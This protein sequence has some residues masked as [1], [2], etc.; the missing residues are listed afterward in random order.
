MKTKK[1]LSLLYCLD[2]LLMEHRLVKQ[3][4]IDTL[5]IS[6]PAF[7]RYKRELRSYLKQFHPEYKLKY[8]RR[9]GVYILVN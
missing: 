2:K 6:H 1:T 7:D 3:E 5:N 9:S 8:N 4:I